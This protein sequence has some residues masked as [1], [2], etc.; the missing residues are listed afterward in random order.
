MGDSKMLKVIVW[1]WQRCALALDIQSRNFVS[2]LKILPGST[3]QASNSACCSVGERV[4]GAPESSILQKRLQ[5]SF[6]YAVQ[7]CFQRWTG[8]SQ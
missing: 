7:I 4:V 6:Y 2:L 8:S 3:S 5:D 1:L